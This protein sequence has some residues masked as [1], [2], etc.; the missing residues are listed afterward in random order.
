MNFQRWLWLE[1]YISVTNGPASSFK[2][3][4][5]YYSRGELFKYKDEKEEAN[6]FS[7]RMKKRR[8]LCTSPGFLSAKNFFLAD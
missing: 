7:I 6:P 3:W 5:L 1:A 2:L 4:W 8:I